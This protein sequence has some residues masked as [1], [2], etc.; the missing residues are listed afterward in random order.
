M[1]AR[2]IIATILVVPP[3]GLPLA[4]QSLGWCR[5]FLEWPNWTFWVGLLLF[6]VPH[7]LGIWAHRAFR[8]HRTTVNPR[9]D[10]MNIMTDADLPVLQPSKFEFVINLKTAKALGLTIP[11]GP[12]SIADEVIE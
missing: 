4:Q 7:A 9:G 3:A 2:W 8:R 1:R 6:T 10:V 5:P 11:S 12:L